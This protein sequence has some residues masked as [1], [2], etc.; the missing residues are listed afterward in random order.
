MPT[1]RYFGLRQFGQLYGYLFG[2]FLVGTGLGPVAMGAIYTRFHSYDSG[3]IVFGIMLVIAFVLMFF[4]GE[5]AYPVHDTETLAGQ[6]A[7]RLPSD[8]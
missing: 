4:L 1:S 6:S 2:V 7:S 5:Y 8:A 3:F